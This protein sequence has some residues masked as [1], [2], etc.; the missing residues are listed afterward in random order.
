MSTMVNQ[1]WVNYTQ[2]NKSYRQFQANNFEQCQ[3]LM[4]QK[5]KTYTIREALACGDAEVDWGIPNEQLNIME[6]VHTTIIMIMLLRDLQN[7][8]AKNQVRKNC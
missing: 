5:G 3:K 8:K 7:H 6:Q 2:Q 4:K 1:D